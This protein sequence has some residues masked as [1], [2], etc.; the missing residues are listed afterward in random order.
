MSTW[1]VRRIS[2]ALAING[3]HRYLEVGVDAGETFRDVPCRERVG[4]DP[5]RV[6][7]DR[8][9]APDGVE[10]NQMTSDEYFSSLPIARQFDVIFLDGL[11]TF[12]Q[13]YRDLCSALTHMHPTSILLVDDVFPQNVFG[14]LTDRAQAQRQRVDHGGDPG[15]SAW[16]GDV[17][18]IVPIVHD[19]HQSLNF[20]TVTEEGKG[21]LIA[22]FGASAERSPVL[23]SLELI[24]R[25]TFF[26]LERLGPIMKYADE[27]VFERIAED[28]EALA[29]RSTSQ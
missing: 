8:F 16:W 17:F 10:F 4:V 26:D 28:F 23:D 20:A 15:D 14:A 21:Q 18:K 24:S 25:L 2:K 5:N 27:S 19:F 1:S 13:I 22:W 7:E 6:V 3:G 29:P 12:E 9:L 11:H